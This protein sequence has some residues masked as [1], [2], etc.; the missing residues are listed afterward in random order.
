MAQVYNKKLKVCNY[1]ISPLRL[2]ALERKQLDLF[3][4]KD[5]Y[6]AFLKRDRNAIKRNPE[7]INRLCGRLY[8]MGLEEMFEKCSTPKE[9][10]RQIGPLFKRWVN[11]K[12]LGI[13]P[14]GLNEFM[15]TKD[16]AI[17]NASDAEM[18][19]WAKEYLGYE[20]N[21]GLDFLITL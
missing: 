18:Q 1:Q 8:E 21:K 10:N 17:L 13:L 6:V 19:L 15:K 12:A 16:D 4:I 5:S 3:P 9:T 20:R 2:Q 7:T 11:S 14:I